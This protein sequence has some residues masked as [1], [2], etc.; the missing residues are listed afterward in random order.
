MEIKRLF[1]INQG[2]VLLHTPEALYDHDLDP[3]LRW[4][5]IDSL[6]SKTTTRDI[7]GCELT[8]M[9]EKEK[10]KKEPLMEESSSP[11]VYTG[12]GKRVKSFDDTSATVDA[13]VTK[14]R[15]EDEVT[16]ISRGAFQNRTSLTSI[17]MPSTVTTIGD[18]AFQRCSSLESI[19]VPS[20]VTTI[21]KFTF[22]GCSSL[23]TIVIPFKVT[24]IDEV[25]FYGCS[26]FASIEIPSSVTTIG[27]DAF[28]D[29]SSLKS[30]LVSSSVTMIDEGAF[31]DC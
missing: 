20:S 23:K 18:S 12:E 19:D 30:I 10:R 29:C 25:A 24:T 7:L 13:K 9:L 4:E 15:V 11:I 21:D 16:T 5:R 22:F 14:A 26:S 1:K 8:D 31:S 2:D 17:K 3:F 6:K 28:S 27:K